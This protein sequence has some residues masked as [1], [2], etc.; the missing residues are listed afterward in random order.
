MVKEKKQ[1]IESFLKKNCDYEFALQG[2]RDV[3]NFFET[4][5]KKGL[6][7]NIG[8]ISRDIEKYGY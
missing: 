3:E 8:L 5:E 4:V 1:I 6:K 7:D 2:L